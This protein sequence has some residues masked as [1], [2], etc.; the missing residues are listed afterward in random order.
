[1]VI[2]FAT[3]KCTTVFL[4]MLWNKLPKWKTKNQ[5]NTTSVQLYQAHKLPSNSEATSWSVLP[6]CKAFPNK[7]LTNIIN[8]VEIREYC[9]AVS[10][11]QNYSL[12][13]LLQVNRGGD[14]PGTWAHQKWRC[15]WRRNSARNLPYGWIVS[16]RNCLLLWCGY[17]KQRWWSDRAGYGR[18]T[19]SPG[20]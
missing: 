10:K 5:P 18:T 13:D 9:N 3:G 4:Y 7:N 1:M 2:C 14:N 6:T 19:A 8:S 17:C 15:G 12:A 16:W 20:S 11:L